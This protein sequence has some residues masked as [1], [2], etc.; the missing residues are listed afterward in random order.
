[1]LFRVFDLPGWGRNDSVLIS[2]ARVM[3]FRG[4]V[5]EYSKE[6]PFVLISLARVMLFRVCAPCNNG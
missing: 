6:D 1:M 5:L 4:S 3:L 2:L